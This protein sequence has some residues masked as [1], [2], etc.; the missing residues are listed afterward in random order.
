MQNVRNYQTNSVIPE[1]GYC[2]ET[3]NQYPNILRE[4]V[5]LPALVMDK[6]KLLNNI[7]WMQ[8]FA[9]TYHVHLAPHGKTSMTPE[10]F[11][12]QINAGAWGMTVANAIQASA[13]YHSGVNRIIMANQLIGKAN[14]DLIS[15]LISQN[16][17]EFCCVIDSIDNLKMLDKYFSDKGQQ[18]NVLIE[19][20]VSHGRCGCRTQ[21]QVHDLLNALDI[22]PSIK[23]AGLEFYE[24]VIHSTNAEQDVRAFIKYAAN[25]FKSD[26]FQSR[27]TTKN[28]IFT[29]AGSAWYDIVCE[30]MQSANLPPNTAPIIRPG[31]YVAH[32]VGIYKDAQNNVLKRNEIACGQ[33]SQLESCLEL[34]A[35][36]QSIPEDGVA[37]IGFG[38]RDSA[39]DAGLPIPNLHYKPGAA[40]PKKVP[41]SWSITDVM[42]QHAFM[43]FQGELQVGD[44]ISFGTSHPCL[45]FDKWREIN[46]V[47]DHFNVVDKYRTYF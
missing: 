2:L 26:A 17:L 40:H 47:D 46:V 37:I 16:D 21:D 38:K 6:T 18:L 31:C 45:T 9:D 29:G 22:S 10:I 23:L 44:L 12:L 43:V 11:K 15:Q 28:P 32:D 8:R 1:K 30:E 20:G 24:G 35:Y 41:S 33:S 34:W 39:F 42:D 7:N 13:A 3:D 25:I 14:F 27:L 19:L 5:S 4:E 36:V